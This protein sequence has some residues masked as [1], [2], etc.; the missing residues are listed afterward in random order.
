[1]SKCE[2]INYNEQ[3]KQL[4]KEYLYHVTNKITIKNVI[5]IHRT[6]R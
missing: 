1:M 5:R 6:L 4:F 3:C 2:V